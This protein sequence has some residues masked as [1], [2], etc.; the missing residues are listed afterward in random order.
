MRHL[1][2][3]RHRVLGV[4][5]G[6]LWRVGFDCCDFC[7]LTPYRKGHGHYWGNLSLCR[8]CDADMHVEYEEYIRE[9]QL[10]E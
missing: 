9:R 10:R 4:I 8:D 5:Q 3:L 6:L 1:Y 7:L 2:W